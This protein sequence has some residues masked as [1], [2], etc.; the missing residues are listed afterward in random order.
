MSKKT[1]AMSSVRSAAKRAGGSHGTVEARMSTME[2][3]VQ[4]GWNRGEQITGID[5]LREKHIVGYVTERQAAGVSERTIAKEL[6]HIRTSMA[7]SGR[8]QA[9]NAAGLMT[10]ALGVTPGSRAGTR[11]PGTKEQMQAAHACAAT[12]DA[13]LAATVSLQMNMG[14]RANE[15]IRAGASLATWAKALERGD[16]V[17]VVLGTKG[18]RARDVHVLDRAAALSAVREAQLVTAERG[19]KIL[20]GNLQQ[21][22]TMHRHAWTRHLSPASGI[23]SHQIRAGWVSARVARCEAE[24]LSRGEALI[25]GGLQLGHGDGRGRWVKN[26]YLALE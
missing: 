26:T 2:H 24:G 1:D 8:S 9:A 11:P 23:H 22:K 21:A 10:K 14:L 20:P 16:T 4:A 17:R 15:A 19:G 3:V 6:S 18:G 12:R 5:G 7:A 13:G 25:E